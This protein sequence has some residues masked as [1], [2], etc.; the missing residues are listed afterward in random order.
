MRKSMIHVVVGT[1]HLSA[2]LGYRLNDALLRPL[3]DLV[4]R[5]IRT[6]N[7]LEELAK[8]TVFEVL[9]EFHNQASKRWCATPAEIMTEQQQEIIRVGRQEYHYPDF[10]VTME[11]ACNS[12]AI[13]GLFPHGT[14]PSSNRKV[15]LPEFS[16]GVR[17]FGFFGPPHDWWTPS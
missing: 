10:K 2:I 1:S 7:S 16:I 17:C 14:L 4:G 12:V 9:N 6:F 13:H 5:P 8:V 11:D 3:G 15:F